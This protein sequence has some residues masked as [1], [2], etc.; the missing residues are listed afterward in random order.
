[1]IVVQQLTMEKV[2][3]TTA[4]TQTT[5]NSVL[6]LVTPMVTLAVFMLAT[7]TGVVATTL[8]FST[9]IC[10][11]PVQVVVNQLMAVT[12]TVTQAVTVTLVAT[13]TLA[14][15]V[16]LVATVVTMVPLIKKKSI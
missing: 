1:M 10:A 14:V 4:E 11:A 16:T 8:M 13:V 5:M 2:F 6:N 9:Q 7:N 3:T 15:T 12:V